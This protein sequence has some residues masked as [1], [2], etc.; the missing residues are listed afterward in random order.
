MALFTKE[1]LQTS[2]LYFLALRH[3]LRM[4]GGEE[5]NMIFNIKMKIA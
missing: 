1:Y 5:P 2:V 3:V 4:G